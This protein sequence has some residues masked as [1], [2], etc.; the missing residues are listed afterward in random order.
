MARPITPTPILTGEDKDRF[1]RS[2]ENL[3]YSAKKERFL[4]ECD[5][6]FESVKKDF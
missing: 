5:R 1:L 3:R 6:V 4:R 2:I